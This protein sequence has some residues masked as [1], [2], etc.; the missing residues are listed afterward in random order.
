[1]PLFFF[2]AGLFATKF[3][4]GNWRALVERKVA[5][6]VWV[7]AVWYLINTGYTVLAGLAIHREPFANVVLTSLVK[8][9]VGLVRPS[10]ELWFLWALA[11]MFIMAKILWDRSNYIR[12]GVPI[13]LAMAVEA[14]PQSI[15]DELYRV[16]GL[17]WMGLAKYTVIFIV[18]SVAGTQF[19]QRIARMSLV[20]AAALAIGATTILVLAF[21]RELGVFHILVMFT[22]LALGISVSRLLTQVTILKALGTRTLPIYVSH[23]SV[24]VVIAL[25]LSKIVPDEV[26]EGS[27]VRLAAPLLI[28]V[29]AI[30]ICVLIGRYGWTAL[31]SPPHWFTNLLL[32]HD[33]V[34]LRANRRQRDD[35]A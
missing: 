5:L 33:R 24:L 19:A 31:F 15:R 13:A 26:V 11:L 21:E 10:N 20:V 14:L 32:R 2:A 6:F 7:F 8:P 22:G 35:E 28:S 29:F 23:T 1:M 30:P 4:A 27:G 18:A 34:A 12:L 9:L 16:L 3:L 17:G 25:L